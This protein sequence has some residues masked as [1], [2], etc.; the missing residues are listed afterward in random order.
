MSQ[1][2]KWFLSKH[3]NDGNKIYSSKYY[4]PEES[5]SKRAV[6]WVNIPITAINQKS[7]S[8]VHLVCQ[9]EPDK[10][11]FHY[12]RVPT[13]FLNEHLEKFHRIG[14]M[15]S[16]YLSAEPITLFVEERGA[17]RLEFNKFLIQK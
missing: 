3:K 10:N 17:G 12:L 1:A 5:W 16:L 9:L 11:D 4:T 2:H 7:Y 6:W 14:E 13:K 8:H 15:I